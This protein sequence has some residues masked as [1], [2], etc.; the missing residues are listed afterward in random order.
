MVDQLSFDFAD[1][2]RCS[3]CK[4]LK[5]RSD[6]HRARK[7]KD[8][9]QSR[10]KECNNDRA[11]RFYADNPERCKERDKRR[12]PG[13]RRQSKLRVLQYLLEHPCVDCGETDPVVLEFDHQRDKVKALSVLV[14]QAASWETLQAEI[15]KCQVRCANCHRRRTAREANNFRYQMTRGVGAERIELSSAG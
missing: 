9:L 14:A 7:N 4:Q 5:L 2:K 13:A 6:F 8:G 10:C 3:G 11:K 1:W 12:K 15:E